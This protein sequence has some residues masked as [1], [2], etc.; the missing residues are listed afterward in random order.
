[1]GLGDISTDVDNIENACA[2]ESIVKFHDAFEL[3]KQ[4]QEATT[5]T[6]TLV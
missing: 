5:D 3:Q 2:M 6:S 4:W 1:M